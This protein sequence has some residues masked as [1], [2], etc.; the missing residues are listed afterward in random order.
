MNKHAERHLALL[1]RRAGDPLPDFD[2]RFRIRAE[3]GWLI[4]GPSSEIDSA[5][6]ALT[7]LCERISDDILL[8]NLGNAV[9][10]FEVPGLGTIEV[11]SGKWNRVHFDR[12]LA[13]LTDIATGLPFA[14][15]GS[16]AL[17]Y[18][19]TVAAREDVLYHM[20]VYLRHALSEAPT[21]DNRLLL[22]LLHILRDPHRRFERTRR[23]VAI[24]QA[25]HLDSAALTAIVTGK[26]GFTRV[27]ADHPARGAFVQ[28][29]GGNLPHQVNEPYIVSSVDTPEN[30]FVKSFL[31]SV[32]GVIDRMRFAAREAELDAFTTRIAAECDRLDA[33][34]RPI[35]QHP[36]W[37]EVGPMVHFPASSPVLQKRRGYRGVYC[38]FAKM[39]LAARV[40]LEPQVVR[41]LLEAKDIA[42]LYELWT[43]FTVVQ[44]LTNL[45]GA[46]IR[47]ASPRIGQLQVT[48]PWDF[49]CVWQNGTRLLYNAQFSRSHEKQRSFSVPLRPDIALTVPTGSNAGLHLFDAKFK[50][51]W[52]T[53]IMPLTDEG[54]DTPPSDVEE[55]RGTFKR[56]DLYKMHTYRDA[57][58]EARS[59]WIF[60]PGTEARFFAENGAVASNVNGL[61]DCLNG[62]GAVPLLPGIDS[63]TELCCVL[64]R[65]LNIGF[66]EIDMGFNTAATMS[67]EVQE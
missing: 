27:T 21:F 50:L 60:Y 49:E 6:T 64:S 7:G 42:Q 45:L 56:G 39:R 12:M 55:R 62:V 67:L 37:R 15:T 4:K 46:P 20:F 57:I 10:F 66:G 18:D 63:H 40:P 14:A 41:D 35:V 43:F 33:Q 54:E 29:L 28:A 16:A 8:L 19:R 2:Q 48:I 22:D 34:L 65:L 23:F 26:G 17:P 58:P 47:A 24:D 5:A 61:P 13:E 3:L 30:R 32:G 31:A 52:L 59:V 38:H 53:E 51:E 11:T 36:L 1:P 25:R 44:E 9:G